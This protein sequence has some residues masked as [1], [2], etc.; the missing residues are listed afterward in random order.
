MHLAITSSLCKNVQRRPIF[1][2]ELGDLA[3][4][5]FCHQYP[6]RCRE[7]AHVDML[8]ARNPP[9]GLQPLSQIKA[10]FEWIH[11]ADPFQDP[12]ILEIF[13]KNNRNL[14]QAAVH[15]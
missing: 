10:L 13:A 12:T 3:S 7:C 2:N 1:F 9:K 14:S 5:S 8:V 11:E 6:G 15:I 4:R